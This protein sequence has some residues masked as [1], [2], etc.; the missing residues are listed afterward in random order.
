[1]GGWVGGYGWAVEVKC[2]GVCHS[3]DLRKSKKEM[4]VVGETEGWRRQDEERLKDHPVR[5]DLKAGVR[6]YEFGPGATCAHARKD[7]CVGTRMLVVSLKQ[8][9]A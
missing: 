2:S 1:M 8:K 7:I 5:G 3:W 6:F 4:C 9:L